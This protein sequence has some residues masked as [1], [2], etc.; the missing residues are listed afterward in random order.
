MTITTTV[1]LA[2]RN[3]A[4]NPRRTG[5]SALSVAIAGLS[6]SFLFA[7][8][9]GMM[10]DFRQNVRTFVSGD[11]RIRHPDYE[12]HELKQPLH[13]AVSPLSEVLPLLEGVEGVRAALPRVNL[14]LRVDH[15]EKS[16]NLKGLGVD[17]ARE[18][19]LMNPARYLHQ[20]RLPQ[21]G[22]REVL[23][24]AS[25]AR[26]LNLGVGDTITTLARTRG[27][28]LNAMTFTISG[29]AVFPLMAQNKRLVVLPLDLTQRLAR[30]GDS[31]QEVLLTL[32]RPAMAPQLAHTISKLFE[33]LG[34]SLA[35]LPHTQIG[36]ASL[37]TQIVETMFAVIALVFF[38]L[39]SAIIINTTLMVIHERTQEIGTLT[40]LGATESTVVRV[41]FLESLLI[42]IIGALV[43]VGLGTGVAAWFSVVGMDFSTMMEGISV[44]FSPVIY[45]QITWRSTLGTLGYGV[46]VGS[47][48]SYFSSRRAA[49]VSPTQALRAI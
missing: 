34:H 44:E 43:G 10:N 26:E 12:A 3:L 27:R 45:P 2:L 38:L 37:Y 29:T 19:A 47:A 24:S 8:S 41:F 48:M 17:F 21:A 36:I 13:L 40:A 31:A 5:L 46:L 15:G 14:G 1:H 20:G 30:L 49:R 11:I 16:Y 23:I 25:L 7:F 28:G 33:K 6:I 22:S 9:D 32:E 42:S 18:T 39:G 35:V 4:R